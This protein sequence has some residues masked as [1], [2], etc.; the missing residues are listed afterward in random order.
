MKAPDFDYVRP[1]SLADAVAALADGGDDAQILAGGQSLMP[2][3]NLRLSQPSRLIDINR[4]AALR[5]IERRGDFVRIGALA[6]HA[7]VLAS[8]VVRCD[9]PLVAAALPHVAHPAI[10]NRG[11]LGG[12]VA[13][14]DPAAE[15]PACCVALD[16]EIALAGPGGERRIEAGDFFRGLY[17]TARRPDEIVTEI[18]FP[19]ARPGE[20]FA[21]DEIARRHGDFAVVGLAIRAE[22]VERRIKRLRMV[23]FGSELH[24]SLSR[25]AAEAGEGRILDAASAAAIAGAF[26]AGLQP[27]DNLHGGAPYKRHIARVLA[28]RLLRKLAP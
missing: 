19:A 28:E 7:E 4:I 2:T 5:G 9:L 14:A 27:L 15:L 11:T 18:R 3:L 25:A 21:F 24:P 13:L 12:S 8:P 1:E 6:R 17:D 10:R 26:A 16:A 23:A 22:L 20:V